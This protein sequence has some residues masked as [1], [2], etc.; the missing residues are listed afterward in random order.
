MPMTKE[1]VYEFFRCFASKEFDY[2][3]KNESEIDVVFS[4][5]FKVKINKRITDIEK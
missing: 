2:V 1:E 5:E 4:D 3:P